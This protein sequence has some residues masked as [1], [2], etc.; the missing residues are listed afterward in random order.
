VDIRRIRPK[1]TWR[2]TAWWQATWQSVVSAMLMMILAAPLIAYLAAQLMELSR[3]QLDLHQ[4][5]GEVAKCGLMMPPYLWSYF[6]VLERI[7]RQR[8]RGYPSGLCNRP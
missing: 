5:W 4:L 7:S 8:N 6:F 2:D 3:Q 1:L